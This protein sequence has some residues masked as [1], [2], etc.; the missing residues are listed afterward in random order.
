MRNNNRGFSLVELLA[1][2]VILGILMGMA[3]AAYSRYK[4]KAVNQAYRTLSESAA[5]GAEEYFMDNINATEVTLDDLV[6]LDYLENVTD[7]A[8]KENKCSGKVIKTNIKGSG[9]N[10]DVI[11]LKVQITCSKF[12]ECMI[13]PKKTKC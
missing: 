4:D 8:S 5:A 2:I 1:V 11:S 12:N 3:V 6:S 9:K 13:Y 10:L 7:P